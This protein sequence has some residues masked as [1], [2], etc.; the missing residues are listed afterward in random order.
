MRGMKL[1][2]AKLKTLLNEMKQKH[3]A[4]HWVFIAPFDLP[5]C[6]AMRA[7]QSNVLDGVPVPDTLL[8]ERKDL[9]IYFISRSIT[10]N[11]FRDGIALSFSRLSLGGPSDGV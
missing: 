10:P 8:M 1:P 9:D 4:T 3:G 6:G 11:P 5:T 7:M 2:F